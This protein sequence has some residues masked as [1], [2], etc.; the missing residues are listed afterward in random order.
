MYNIQMLQ[1][2]IK[3]VK[4][5]QG[6]QAENSKT[7][8]TS[9][10]LIAECEKD[11]GFPIPEILKQFWIE[12]GHFNYSNDYLTKGCT[13]CYTYTYLINNKQVKSLY[14]FLAG[15]IISKK[16]KFEG[17]LL[18]HREYFSYCVYVIACVDK[19]VK[20]K[21]ESTI[22]YIDYKQRIGRFSFTDENIEEVLLPIVQVNEDATAYVNNRKVYWEEAKE[23]F[24]K[25]RPE[26]DKIALVKTKNFLD[27]ISKMKTADDAIR[28]ISKV[29]ESQ[30]ETLEKQLAYKIPQALKDFWLKTGVL[31]AYLILNHETYNSLSVYPAEKSFLTPNCNLYDFLEEVFK[32]KIELVEA[33]SEEKPY[34]NSCFWV[35]AMLQEIHYEMPYLEIFYIDALGNMDSIRFNNLAEAI[36]LNPMLNSLI[37]IKNKFSS[38]LQAGKGEVL[39]KIEKEK[40]KAEEER[41]CQLKKL[42]EQNENEITMKNF[43]EISY[44]EALKLLNIDRLFEA[45]NEYCED[46]FDEDEN[47]EL[48]YFSDCTVYYADKDTVI[49]G[50]LKG[51]GAW[52]DIFIVN[53]N[54]TVNGK[55]TSNFYVTGNANFEVLEMTNYQICKGKETVKYLQ[56][57]FAED[58]EVTNFSRKRHVS[59]PYYFSWFYS[60][61]PLTFD[62]NTVIFALYD[63][64][65]QKNYKT[66]NPHIAWQNYFYVLKNEL[67]YSYDYDYDDGFHYK[68][69]EIANTLQEGKSIFL[70]GFDVACLPFF[71]KGKDLFEENDFEY[72]FLFFK[73]TIELSP[74]FYLAYDY[75]GA[76]LVNVKAYQQ[77]FYYYEKG[78][79]KL[80]KSVYL[81]EIECLEQAVLC[82]F[83]LNEFEKA[84]SILENAP[85]ICEK[86]SFFLRL[87]GE[88]FL[89]QNKITK[90]K[91]ALEKSIELNNAFT[92][93]W[94]LGLIYSQ[95]S[96]TKKAAEI[97]KIASAKSDK[98]QPYSEQ[99]NL[100]Y[101]YGNPTQVD[102]EN[103]SIDTQKTNEKG[104]EYWTDFFNKKKAV[105]GYDDF[106]SVIKKIPQEFRTK[107][108]LDD[109]L[110]FLYDGKKLVSGRI[111]NLFAHISLDW[112]IP[113]A[114][115]IYC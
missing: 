86:S 3:L 4:E 91:E 59:A 77:A 92:N 65:D 14:N 13:G 24:D 48:D 31:K 113:L 111:I 109:A 107:N 33:Y 112:G 100:A 20:D 38:F 106:E 47:D 16:E 64:D 49:E 27:I 6:K 102:W 80:P 61:E 115:T 98:S 83:Q 52:S 51:S 84:A 71:Q 63:W 19:K 89:H 66:N 96:D 62:K 28:V 12:A 67:V 8:P 60:L 103:K 25:L 87:K 99:Q 40:E 26:R 35:Y 1:D 15:G 68:I 34:L 94:L 17:V 5:L 82:A 9:G 104:Q 93:N 18:T 57:Q 22:Y 50:N 95:E 7:V 30:I 11:L 75:A 53:G 72:A 58:H 74:N 32:N 90:A 69:S 81:S 39:E 21:E 2:L 79:L 23:I 29:Q 78:I 10:A 76:A 108:M 36:N 55:M 114:H 42:K 73:K 46:E 54:L 45:F 56:Y 37:T 43:K 110:N 101:Y 70:D 105:I 97:Y 41:K 85:E 44:E 88:L